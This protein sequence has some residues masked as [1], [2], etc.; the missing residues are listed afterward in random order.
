MTMPSFD[1]WKPKF[2]A[3]FVVDPMMGASIEVFY[4]DHTAEPFDR[5]GLG[6]VVASQARTCAYGAGAR[7]V[8]D[9]LFAGSE[10]GYFRVGQRRTFRCSW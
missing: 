8:S 2:P 7:T 1:S 6:S 9:E 10:R 5:V 4:S 3:V